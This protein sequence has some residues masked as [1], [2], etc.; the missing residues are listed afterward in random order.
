MYNRTLEIKRTLDGRVTPGQNVIFN[1]QSISTPGIGYD[2]VTG[3]ITFNTI[4]QYSVRWWV[5]TETTPKGAI[6]FGLK[7]SS[8]TDLIL[9]SSPQ[10][11]GQVSGFAAI[12]ILTE[13]TTMTLV[14]ST[15]TDNVYS[16]EV[17][18]KA[19]L[20]VLPIVSAEGPDTGAIIPFSTGDR[21]IML[22][23]NANGGRSMA[24]ILGFAT[25]SEIM[26]PTDPIVFFTDSQSEPYYAFTMPTA[27]TI[28]ALS[29]KFILTDLYPE[30]D[31]IITAQLY[32]SPTLNNTFTPVP[33]ATVALGTVL[34]T[35]PLGK[36]LN[37]IVTGLSVSISAQTSL[38]LIFYNTTAS[39]VIAEVRGVMQGGLYIA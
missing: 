33:G 29:A 32:Y 7:F 2:D 37:G 36:V 17:A 9:G 20:L 35:D 4:G 38:L 3:T 25:A 14:N 1:Q 19:Y 30:V 12:D 24:A 39:S 31:N 34:R 6:E 21:P 18:L 11:T 8:R 28:T 26:V 10:K 22:T 16:R 15:G 23:T 13:G 27:G 5:A